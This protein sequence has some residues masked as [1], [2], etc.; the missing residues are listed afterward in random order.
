MFYLIKNI[1]VCSL[2][3]EPNVHFL[4]RGSAC[5]FKKASIIILIFNW[6]KPDVYF[7]IDYLIRH[8]PAVAVHLIAITMEIF[9]RIKPHKQ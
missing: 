4:S 8:M 5:S 3:E 9:E 2:E 7:D 1:K 6:I